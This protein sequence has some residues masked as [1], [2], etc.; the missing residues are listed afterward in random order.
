MQ[1]EIIRLQSIIRGRAARILFS[2]KL[3]CCI[4][5]QSSVRRFLAN[6]RAL[7][8]KL[9]RAVEGASVEG[10]RVK[11]ACRRIQFW[12]RVV[13]ECSRE[14][15]AALVIER[16]FLMVKAEVDNEIIRQ[17]EIQ[18]I[19]E[20]SQQ[21][22]LSSKRYETT[23]RRQDTKDENL[24]ER[25][26]MNTVDQ[27]SIDLIACASQDFVAV[28]GQ[29]LIPPRSSSAPRLHQN[30][31]FIS[32]P[33]LLDS[34]VGA[35]HGQTSSPG[36]GVRHHPSSPSNALVMRHE[37]DPVLRREKE[38]AARKEQALKA[39]R[40]IH[41]SKPPPD[42]TLTRSDERTEVSAITS[43]TIFKVGGSRSKKHP[44]QAKERRSSAEGPKDGPSAS[45]RGR[46]SSGNGRERQS[47]SVPRKAAKQHFFSE[48][49]GAGRGSNWGSNATSRRHSTSSSVSAATED[50]A[51]GSD[52]S[53]MPYSKNSHTATTFTKTTHAETVSAASTTS[54]CHANIDTRST[55]MSEG[56]S[57]PAMVVHRYGADKY[58]S[59]A[60][61]GK[62]LI[63]AVRSNGNVAQS[64]G[65]PSP[66]HGR[67]VVTNA[68]F[69]IL[70]QDSR[71][72]VEV[73]YAGE[74]FGMI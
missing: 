26:W 33:S 56:L 73:E 5:I 34:A 30:P 45:D 25:V 40:R 37:V 15:K 7:E 11:L 28:N 17:R 39:S 29:S 22:K 27:D 74:Q 48:D 63:A 50:S 66:R 51:I 59:A 1:Y 61:K 9:S 54:G 6:K 14:K 36:G 72:N 68:D 64:G 3:G 71:D 67:I 69:P 21:T 38:L 53:D 8:L 10:L 65:S 19:E 42:V 52:F 47:S 20:R 4:M 23:Q 2:L 55:V 44:T 60:S 32:E 12:W 16:F 58:M 24:L 43:P 62:K 13:M 31:S 70:S 18:T 49:M 35:H 41:K 57:S 46:Q